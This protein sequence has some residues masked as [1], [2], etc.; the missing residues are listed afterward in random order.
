MTP[1]LTLALRYALFAA[2]ATAA[3]VGVQAASLEIYDGTRAL[4]LAMVLG[5]GVGLAVKYLLD[6]RWIFFDRK[7]SMSHD[8]RQFGLY[9]GM[10]VVTTAVFWLTELAFDAMSPDL[11]FVGAAIGLA[12]GY[13]IKYHLDRRFVFRAAE[14]AA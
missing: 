11:R 3:N 2:L 1:R 6:K 4:A 10:G 5:T 13:Q 8:G 7:T 14:A 9:T 12:I